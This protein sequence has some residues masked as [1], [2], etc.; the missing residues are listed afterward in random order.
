MIYAINRWTKLYIEDVYEDGEVGPLNEFSGSDRIVGETPEQLIGN[1]LGFLG[2]STD[3]AG[4]VCLDE[5]RA[6]T[7]HIQRLETVDGCQ[8]N[9]DDI[10]RWQ[11]GRER[12]WNATYTF[13]VVWEVPVESGLAKALHGMVEQVDLLR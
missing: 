4:A 11:Q 1:A 5:E 8:A 10:E 13:Q 6:D 2:M 7:I 3:D 9:V 12:L